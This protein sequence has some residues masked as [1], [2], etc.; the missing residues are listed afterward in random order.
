MKSQRAVV[1]SLMALACI[2]AAAI[3]VARIR[4]RAVIAPAIRVTAVAHQWW[5]E[6]DY[7]SL[8]IKTSDVLYLPSSSDVQLELVSDDVIHSFWIQGMKN[9]IDIIPGKSRLLDLVVKS[10]GEL[11][12]NC[13]SGCGCGTVCMRFRVIA[14]A[15]AAFRQWALHARLRRAEFMAPNTPNTPACALDTGYVGHG[16]RN[17]PAGRMQQLLDN[18]S[19]AKAAAAVRGSAAQ[20]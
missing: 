4:D 9:S 13:D 16:K 15:P 18:G 20:N 10:P 17:S 8:G 12:G 2:G 11:H 5:W 1:G 7:S 6:F 14:S 3:F 19:T